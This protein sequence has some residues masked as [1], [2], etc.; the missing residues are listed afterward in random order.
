ML[1]VTNL[2]NLFKGEKKL[3]FFLHKITV[4]KFQS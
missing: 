2:S 1:T 3:F 4:K